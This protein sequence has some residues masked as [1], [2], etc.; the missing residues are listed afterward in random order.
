MCCRGSAETPLPGFR[1]NLHHRLNCVTLLK[2]PILLVP[3]LYLHNE[4]NGYDGDNDGH[5]SDAPVGK[6]SF[7]DPWEGVKRF[8]DP[9]SGATAITAERVRI[10]PSELSVNCSNDVQ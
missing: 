9:L 10:Q 3:R 2:R 5:S 1:S 4:D 7:R 6:C 8:A